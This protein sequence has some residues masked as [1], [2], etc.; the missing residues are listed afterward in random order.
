VLISQSGFNKEKYISEG[1]ALGSAT[2]GEI[3]AELIGKNFKNT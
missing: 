1:L 3:L 2:L